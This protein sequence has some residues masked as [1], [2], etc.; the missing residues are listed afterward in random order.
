MIVL[1]REPAE[2]KGR[3]NHESQQMTLSHECTPFSEK[4]WMTIHWCLH[5]KNRTNGR[6]GIGIRKC[7]ECITLNEY[8]EDDSIAFSGHTAAF[9]AVYGGENFELLKELIL[10]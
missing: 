10:K 6:F 9:A 3:G 8:I 4:I 1:F 2:P 7:K 5:W